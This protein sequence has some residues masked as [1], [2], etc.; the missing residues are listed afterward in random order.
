[1]AALP[2]IPARVRA[3][4]ALAA[5]CGLA[6][7][8]AT[9]GLPTPGSDAGEDA[10]TDGRDAAIDASLDG[11]I[12]GGTTPDAWT[13]L[14]SSF[15]TS[16]VDHAF[17]TG[18]SHGQATAFPAAVLGPPQANDSASVVSLGNGGY[19]VLAFDELAI[20][21]GPGT[22]F[23]VFEN[24]FPGFV[25][26]ATV[27]VSDDGLVWHEFPCTAP[28]AGPDYGRCAGVHR[29][30]SSTRNGVPATDPSVSGGDPYDLAEL[31]LQRVRFV[32][33]TDRVDLDGNA[34]VF[35]LDAVAVVHGECARD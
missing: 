4:M 20:V 6:G 25:E 18:Q 16:V 24:P 12:E 7:C 33:I 2:S 35:D 32:R 34:G 1:M 30:L 26:L 21:D 27:A 23:T 31:G 11:A 5:A 13:S 29:V 28:Q 14:C 8:Y 22:D 3:A 19:V 9:D 17:G 15:A 10:Q